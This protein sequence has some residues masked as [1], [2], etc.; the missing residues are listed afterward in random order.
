MRSLRGRGQGADL[1]TEYPL[2]LTPMNPS[3]IVAGPDGA[4]WFTEFSSPG[5]RIGRFQL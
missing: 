2:P 5:G 4:I 1:I 3:G